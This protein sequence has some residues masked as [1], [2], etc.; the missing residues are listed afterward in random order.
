MCAHSQSAGM[1]ALAYTWRSSEDNFVEFQA[2]SPHAQPVSLTPS[3]LLPT[4]NFKM[5]MTSM[6]P[7]AAALLI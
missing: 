5:F 7:H 1:G 2:A 6:S 4:P 3:H